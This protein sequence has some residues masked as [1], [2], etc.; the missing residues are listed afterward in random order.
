MECGGVSHRFSTVIAGGTPVL[1][2][3]RSCRADRFSVARSKA[4]ARRFVSSGFVVTRRHR[5]PHALLGDESCSLGLRAKPALWSGG[6]F[7]HRPLA[8]SRSRHM[9]GGAGARAGARTSG[10]WRCWLTPY[11][12][13]YN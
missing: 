5:T 8:W 7:G 9:L 1:Y 3:L 4:V 12:H 6:R 13:F 11:V 2:G 10:H